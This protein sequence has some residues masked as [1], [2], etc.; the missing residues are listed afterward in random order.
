MVV[1]IRPGVTIITIISCGWINDVK[2]LS[3]LLLYQLT[4]IQTLS[5]K[6]AIRQHCFVYIKPFNFVNSQ[7]DVDAILSYPVMDHMAL[8]PRRL[9]ESMNSE[10]EREADPGQTSDVDSNISVEVT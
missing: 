10:N 6:G 7:N 1:T 2:L 4:Q 9:V 5:I 3:E 8:Q